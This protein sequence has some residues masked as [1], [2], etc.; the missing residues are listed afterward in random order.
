MCL[1]RTAAM[2]QHDVQLG[3]VAHYGMDERPGF[4]PDS[5]HALTA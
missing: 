3:E 5:G 2:T 4:E 1:F